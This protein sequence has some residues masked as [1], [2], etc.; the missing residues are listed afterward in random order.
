MVLIV[1]MEFI[2]SSFEYVKSLTSQEKVLFIRMIIALIGEDDEVDVKERNFI[3]EISRQYKISKSEFDLVQI[4]CSGEELI[5]EAA[6]ILDRNKSLF[7]IKEL[8]TVANT[9]NDLDDREIDFIIQLSTA[10]NIEDEKIMEINQLV[11]DQINLLER[12]HVV[13]EV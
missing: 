2:M 6:D 5:N 11:L 9:D 7:L 10:L 8:L 13:M 12:Y 4:R 3:K 1:I